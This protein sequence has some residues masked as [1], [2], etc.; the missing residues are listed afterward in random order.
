MLEFDARTQS[1]IPKT[2]PE[3]PVGGEIFHDSELSR[4]SDFHCFFQICS[5][6]D[7]ASTVTFCEPYNITAKIS[8]E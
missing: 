5:M 8:E 4:E 1:S 7:G 3:S 2:D 6:N